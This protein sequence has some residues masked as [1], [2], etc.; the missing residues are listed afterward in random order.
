MIIIYTIAKSEAASDGS[1]AATIR[2]KL[3]EP[4]E[5]QIPSGAIWIDLI[6]PTVEEDG[7][8]QEFVGVLVPTKADPDYTEPRREIRA[9]ILPSGHVRSKL[10]KW[11]PTKIPLIVLEESAR[12]CPSHKAIRH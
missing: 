2:R 3:L 12:L 1:T 9:Q 8:V 4:S 6:E 11:P 7:K 5:M 10:Q